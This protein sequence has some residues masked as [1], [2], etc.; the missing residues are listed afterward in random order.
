MFQLTAT[1]NFRTALS[2]RTVSD[3]ILQIRLTADSTAGAQPMTMELKWQVPCIGVHGIWTPLSFRDSAI[4][5]DWCG[6]HSFNCTHSAPVLTALDYADNNRM[7][8]ACADAKNAVSIKC[9]V[10]E[11]TG[12][13]D[14]R[15]IIRIPSAITHYETDIRI[16]T[17][18]IKFYKS[19][20]DI[21]AW[22]E[23]FYPR[24][25]PVDPV[26]ELP[27]YSSW[28]NFHHQPNAE[29]LE[30]ELAL[31]AALG[32]KA[33]IIDDGW[34]YEGNGT[35]DYRDCG[36]WAVAPG[37]F[38]DFAAFVRKAHDLGIKVMLWFPVP[39]IGENTEAY[40]TFRDCFLYYDTG[41]RAGVLDPRRPAGRGRSSG[42][43]SCRRLLH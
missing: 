35:S 36:N 34:Q 41:S 7:T 24:T 5:A 27:L 20:D 11:E 16:D 9:G 31:A 25:L 26:C 43:A 15:V 18:D 21:A 30:Q 13:L 39:F 6:P 37:K 28:Y 2:E 4:P 40:K 1:E 32:F 14:C 17:R 3:G 29:Q 19:V 8:I 10:I 23:T 42:Y 38:P 22:W 12:D 33:A